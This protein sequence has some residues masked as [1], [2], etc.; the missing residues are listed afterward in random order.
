MMVLLMTPLDREPDPAP[1]ATIDPRLLSMPTP[2]LL[3]TSTCSR[4]SSPVSDIFDSTSTS[5][6]TGWSTPSTSRDSTPVFDRFS[7]DI[8]AAK[9]LHTKSPCKR[10]SSHL[11]SALSYPSAPSSEI[12]FPSNN[13]IKRE[14]SELESICDSEPPLKRIH[15]SSNSASTPFSRPNTPATFYSPSP[16]SQSAEYLTHSPTSRSPSPVSSTK[17]SKTKSG[18][19]PRKGKAKPKRVR[20]CQNVPCTYDNCYNIFSREADR[21]RHIAT[22]HNRRTYECEVCG[23][24]CSREDALKRHRDTFHSD[25]DE[26][27]I[28]LNRLRS[29]GR[30]KISKS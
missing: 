29:T 1:V 25:S 4:S 3:E 7:A 18:R 5:G 9:Q 10:S 27:W 15:L 22:V 20:A 23:K 26:D 30:G 14:F 17:L 6:S 19:V 2:S 11:D 21:D 12:Y 13:A 24:A 28:G 8:L 16:R